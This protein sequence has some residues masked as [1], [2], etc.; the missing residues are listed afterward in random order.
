MKLKHLSQSVM[1][2]GVAVGAFSS[3]ALA[4]G[5]HFG[6]QSVSAQGTAFANSAEAS[7]ASTI[8]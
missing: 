2:M 1:L 7:G 6:S 5:Y 3:T 8:L 4:S